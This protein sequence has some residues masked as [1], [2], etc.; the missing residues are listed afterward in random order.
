[1]KKALVLAL[2]A[3]T[4]AG[5]TAAHAQ[6]RGGARGLRALEGMKAKETDRRNTR[7]A[8]PAVTVSAESV[9]V[10]NMLATSGLSGLGS[11]VQAELAKHANDPI[12]KKGIDSAIQNKAAAPVLVT[13]QLTG[14]SLLATAKGTPA[15]KEILTD[16]LIGAGT[17]AAKWPDAKAKGN[18][19]FMIA[20]TNEYLVQNKTMDQALELAKG[21]L[22][23]EKGVD[24]ELSKIK[25]LCK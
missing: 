5:T 6:A 7:N 18:V 11:N 9:R 2:A 24:I 22:L 25:D 17:K 20:R 12:I 3:I 4:L 16:L 23:K 8:A 15:A 19:E 14:L 21:D 10:Q 13:A 1:M